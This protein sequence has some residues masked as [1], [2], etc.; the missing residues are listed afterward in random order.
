[1]YYTTVNAA[2]LPTSGVMN[3]WGP[4]DANIVWATGDFFFL[5]CSLF[6]LTLF[7]L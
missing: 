1:M 6:K 5:K 3:E 2:S 4:N 7:L